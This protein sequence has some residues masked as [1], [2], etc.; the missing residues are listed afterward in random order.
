MAS[1]DAT[2]RS[3]GVQDRSLSRRR[4]PVR[5]A[6]LAAIALAT[7]VATVAPAPAQVPTADEATVGLTLVS[8]GAWSRLGG[9][10]PLRLRVTGRRPGL[11]LRVAV[12]GRLSSRSAFEQTTRGEGLGSV[13]GRVTLPLDLLETTRRGD[14]LADLALQEPGRGRER[15]QL[16]VTRAGVYP[17]TV[18]IADPGEEALAGFTTWLVAVDTDP[19]DAPLAVAWIWPVVAAPYVRPDGTPDPAVAAELTPG[20][21]LDQAVAALT[22]ARVPLTLSVGPETL[23]SWRDASRADDRLAARYDALRVLARDPDNELLPSPYVPLDLP[24]LEAGGLGD[25]LVPELLAGA[26][27]LERITGRR[28]D[29]RTAYVD[30][31]DAGALMRL[32]G[33]FVDRVAVRSEALVPVDRRLT[34][35]RPFTLST[36]AL[37]MRATAT[38]SGL[39]ALLEGPESRGLRAQRFLAGLSLVALE[40]PSLDRGVVFAEPDRWQPDPTLLQ[41]VFEGLADHPLL[42]AI[43]LDDYFDRVPDDTDEEGGAP[44]VR[45]LVPTLPTPHPVS[46]RAYDDAKAR[47]ASFGEV[48]GADDQR[49]HRGDQALLVGLSS[50]LD[51]ARASAY[52]AVVDRVASEFL[53]GITTSD[54]TITLTARRAEIPL[55]FE[56]GTG[57][58]VKVRV[59]LASNKLLFPDGPERILELA[60]GNT[61]VRFPVRA[62]ASGTFTMTVAITS[63]DGN[64]PIGQPTKVTIRS[65]VFSGY[66]TFLMVGAAVFLAVWWFVHALRRRRAR[67][68]V[69][70]P[71]AAA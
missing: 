12:H 37:S 17:M 7:T 21:R 68:S 47:L 22:N 10:A 71:G 53:S 24:A 60:E 52:L 55:S 49:V 8:Q 58:P 35:S 50:M 33:A 69:T 44:L 16:P 62:R 29:P 26:D 5:L 6:L 54:K 3:A 48:V 64:L 56:N 59:R 34:E 31:V 70:E 20:G 43:T 61:T 46:R 13:L 27:V 67:R 25:E 32:R 9:E 1:G 42:E 30:P 41:L 2:V 66:G 11:E 45:A 63:E 39:R 23:A 65:T 40:A 51:A 19:I 14:V 57:R 4:H 18:E 36:H 28:V 15:T 38:S